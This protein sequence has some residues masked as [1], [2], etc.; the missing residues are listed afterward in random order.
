MSRD[1][2]LIIGA[3]PVGLAMADALKREQL[4][5]DHV[6]ANSG[7]GGN[8]HDGVFDTT[9]IVSSKGTTAYSDYPMPA[10][11]PDFPSASQMLDYLK[12]YA[13]DRG[14]TGAIELNRKVEKTMPNEDD[15][16]DVTFADGEK[17]TYKGVIV[18]NGHHWAKRFPEIPGKF[19]GEY[20]HSKDYHRADQLAGKRV[21]VI[22]AGNSAHDVACDAAR[23]GASCDLSLRSGYWFMPKTAF[24][25]P[26]TDLPIWWMPVFAQRIAL[27]AIIKVM[28][29]DYRRYGLKKPNHRIFDRHPTYG[30]DLLNYLR[31]GT[32]KPR[33]EIARFEDS[34]VRF[35]DGTVSEY[36]IVV[37]A[38]GFDYSFPFLPDTLIDVK[39]D[40]VQIYGGAFPDKVKNLYIVGASQPRGGF[41]R[42]VTP[43]AKLYARM[44]KLQDD[45]HF[46][47]GAILKWRNN[48]IPKT[49]FMDAESTRRRIAL[50]HYLLP[51][52]K[53]QDKRMAKHETREIWVPPAEKE[54]TA[55]LPD[56]NTGQEAA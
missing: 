9:H 34:S 47:I 49:Q 11:Y 36:D 3:G 52:L 18:C 56:N 35:K 21:L 39:N 50:S 17:R 28:I 8:W 26:L 32:V 22:G 42:V 5:Y 1:K 55:T 4:P 51:L 12:A 43:A 13:H 7:I 46:P 40:V 30:T 19:T 23:V 14:L 41:G 33:G 38:T 48:P 16:W 6:D 29:G 25:M 45:L 10:D 54:G 20:I 37:A 53:R 31:L 2:L 27:R 15:S 44:M 24:G